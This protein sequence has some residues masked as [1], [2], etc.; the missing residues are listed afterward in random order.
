MLDK[1]AGKR[2]TADAVYEAL[3]PF[4]TADTVTKA[5]DESRDPTRPFRR[6]LLAGP[7]G[8]DAVGGQSKLTDAEA[9]QIRGNAKALLDEEHATEAIRLLESGLERTDDPFLTLSLRH[10]LAAAFFYD[11][12]YTRA[13]SLFDVVGREYRRHM[14]PK[15]PFVLECA[16]YAGHAYAAIGKP[17]KALPQLRFYVLNADPAADPEEAAKYLESRFVIA[18]MLAAEEQIEEAVAELRSVRPLMVAAYGSDAVMIHNLDKQIDL[19]LSTRDDYG[20]DR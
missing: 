7:K 4:I 13:A 19:L 20:S 17:D 5:H 1:D 3:L 2:P 8:K 11:G 16:Y 10:L 18:Q 6:P 14:D 12:E 9:E 15:D